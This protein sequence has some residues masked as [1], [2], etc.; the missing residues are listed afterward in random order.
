MELIDKTVQDFAS[1][2]KSIM[3]KFNSGNEVLLRFSFPGKE[4]LSTING[5]MALSL[6]S[7]DL[8]YLLESIVTILRECV[9]NATKANT[10]RLFF[11]K[12]GADMNDQETYDSV[13][14]QFKDDIIG[15]FETIRKELLKSDFKVDFKLKKEQNSFIIKVENNAVIHPNEERRINER[16]L[17]ARK[18]NDFNE[19]YEQMF[20]ETE[21]A[22]LGIILT[23]ML[24]KNLGIP[25]DNFSIK[26]EN[27]KTVVS[28]IIPMQLKTP[29]I[30]TEVKKQIINEIHV[31]PTFP[32]NVIELIELCDNPEANISMMAQKIQVD[33][34][35]TADVLKLA[36]SAGFVSAKRID[37]INEAL[38]RIGL[39]NLKY[40]LI[41]ASSREIMDKR[42]KKFEM[43]WN[44]CYKVGFYARHLALELKLNSI[45][46]KVFI[47]SVLHDLGKIILLSVDLSL[48]EWIS[49]FVKERGI[50]TTT[51][52]EEVS[53]GISHSAIGKLLA[54]KWNFSEF[55]TEGIA[56]HH[57]PLQATDE[58]KSIV[59]LTYFA[60][61]L[62]GIESKKYDYY[63]IDPIVL[64]HLGP[65][66]ENAIKDIH[67]KIK[68]EF[69]AK[70]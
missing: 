14:L 10:K 52:L 32:K 65:F 7:L 42:Y 53:L 29:E 57:S 56:Y 24:L 4:V 63:Y 47:S 26:A 49:D 22:G 69:L 39:S 67:E 70:A 5:I 68:K 27:R 33:P 51:I 61:I 19:A 15:D 9:L 16:I 18:F 23:I 40:I 46:E 43:I 35:L 8:M 54:E 3:D 34:S 12:K 64:D 44:H 31:L 11:Q 58:N 36:N 55:L 28:L 62:C 25:V 37:T 45:A 30:V 6:G 2:N 13:M 59:F 21:G 66:T 50:R 17:N 41:A 48:T 38:M 60:N 20:D 1:R